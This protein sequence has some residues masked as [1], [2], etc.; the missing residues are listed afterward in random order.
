MKRFRNALLGAG[1]LAVATA[2]A[3]AADYYDSGTTPT[4]ATGL[5][6]QLDVGGSLLRWD[7]PRDDEAFTIGGGLGYRFNP[8]MRAD[9]LFNYAGK[10]DI[11]GGTDLS[12]SSVTGNLYLDMP[13]EGL[14]FKP[15]LGAGLGYGWATRSPGDDDGGLAVAFKAGLNWTLAPNLELD[16]GYRFRDIMVDGPNVTEHQFLVGLRYNF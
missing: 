5:Y 8:Y 6:L 7:G 13:I 11:G 12:A 3:L 1:L 4:A 10:Y 2:P 16:T 14:P 15:Y 9:V